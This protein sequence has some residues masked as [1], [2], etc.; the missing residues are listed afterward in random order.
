VT[1]YLRTLE[2]RDTHFGTFSRG[3]INAECG[4]RFRPRIV[5]YGHQELPGQPLDPGHVCLTR[6]SLRGK[7][8][9]PATEVQ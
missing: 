6:K 3:V 2:D 9:P 7:N 4:T 8:P 1:W 5:A